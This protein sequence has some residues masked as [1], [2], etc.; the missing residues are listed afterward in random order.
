ME[1]CGC[2]SVKWKSSRDFFSSMKVYEL[3][4]FNGPNLV[5]RF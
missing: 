3:M 4:R 5:V 1:G 2:V